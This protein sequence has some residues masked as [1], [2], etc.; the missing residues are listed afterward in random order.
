MIQ[1]HDLEPLSIIGRYAFSLSCI[2]QLCQAWDI[3][4]PFVWD[5][6]DT[7]WTL[8]TKLLLNDGRTGYNWWDETDDFAPPTPVLL[9][10]R[11]GS[12]FLS[13]D[14]I[15]SLFHGIY[16]LRMLASADMYCQPESYRSMTHALNIVGILNRWGVKLPSLD[17]FRK[18]SYPP[19]EFGAGNDRFSRTEFL[20][21]PSGRGEP[22]APADRPREQGFSNHNAKPA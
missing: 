19:E 8:T 4:D 10:S 17:P 11:I 13:S 15:Q 16:E 22:V 6:I 5:M 21:T 20:G 14:Q 9:G 12:S 3:H 1:A 7:H 18:A 2:E